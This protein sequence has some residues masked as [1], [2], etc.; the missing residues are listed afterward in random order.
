M[1]VCFAA[2]AVARTDCV[3]TV[4]DLLKYQDIL[5]RDVVYSVVKRNLG[6]YWT[7]DHANKV[8]FNSH[9]AKVCLMNV[10]WNILESSELNVKTIICC[11]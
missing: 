6:D 1:F 5:G 3:T 2:A 4:M 11:M 10:S 7:F 8:K 9:S